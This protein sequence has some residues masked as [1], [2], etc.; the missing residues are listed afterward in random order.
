MADDASFPTG[1]EIID[2]NRNGLIERGVERVDGWAKVTGGALYAYETREEGAALYGVAV[3]G[4]AGLAHV[5]AVD[6]SAARAAPGVRLAWGAGDAPEQAPFG[7][8]SPGAGMFGALASAKPQLAAPEARFFG[9][10]VALV[11]A[12]TFENARAASALVRVDYAREAGAYDFE[13]G[14]DAAQPPKESRDG[15]V[16]EFDAAFADAPVQLD[17]TYTTPVQNHAQMEPHAS[18]AVWNGDHLTLHT[19]TQLLKPAQQCLAETL[20]IPRAQVRVVS[21]YI[22]GGFGGKLVQNPDAILAALAARELGA[23]VKVALS[24]QQTFST[25][26]HRSATVQRVRL[27]ATQEGRLTAIAHEGINHHARFSEFNEGAPSVTRS[28]YAAPN[29]RIRHRLVPLDI[30]M[31]G[32]VRAPGEAVG[33]LAIEVAMDE[34][35]EQLGIDPIELRVLNEPE[36]DPDTGK[37]FGS[38]SL[39]PCMREGAARFGWD[40]RRRPGEVR[41]GRWLVGLGMSAS[42]R[43]NFLLPARA[44]LTLN[45]EGRATVRQ[46]MTDIGTGTYT[47]LAQIAAEA[48]GISVHD[49]S[50]EIGDSDFPPAPGSGG[51]FGAA[52]A[53]SALLDAAMNLRQDLAERAVADADSPLHGGRPEEAIFV[54][55]RI[56]IGNR[57]ERLAD[58]MARVAPNGLEAKGSLTPPPTYNDFSQHAHGAHFAEVGVDSVTGEVRLRRMLGVFAAGRILNAQTARSQALGGMIWGV[59]AALTEENH[60][61]KRYGSFGNQDLA[62]Y[63]VPAHADIADLDAMFIA[64][65]DDHGNPMKIKGVGELGICGAGAAVANAIYNACG[66]RLRDYPMTLDKVLA[67]GVLPGSAVDGA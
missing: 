8:L 36:R 63:H 44:G 6:L 64:E 25:T 5:T 55:G 38:R 30:S 16:G 67:A 66:A 9:D 46:A 2:A 51:S 58:L 56:L 18:L 10:V 19:S 24:R 42:S 49:V 20:M 11:V 22:G 35:A 17:R 48:L 31:A 4:Q 45:V 14:L 23:P 7:T 52:S 13:A 47:I 53:G 50:V 40:R 60:I 12:D 33:M 41:D 28:L 29:R 54:E 21:R 43:A 39:V 59:G 3:M 26:T 62:S 1:A 57:G 15:D 32:A 27:G 37:P 65:Q 61:D 34:L